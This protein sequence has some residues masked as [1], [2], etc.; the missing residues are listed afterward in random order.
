MV[1]SADGPTSLCSTGSP[2]KGYEYMALG[3]APPEASSIFATLEFFNG[4][5]LLGRFLP[6]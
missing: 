6:S 5:P 2:N 3:G 1:E 4:R